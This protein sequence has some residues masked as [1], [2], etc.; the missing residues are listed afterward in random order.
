MNAYSCPHTCAKTRLITTTTPNRAARTGCPAT[1]RA[2]AASAKIASLR[3]RSAGMGKPRAR[4]RRGEPAPHQSHQ[5]R[6]ANAQCAGHDRPAA[7]LEPPVGQRG[8][9]AQL[10]EEAQPQVHGFECLHHADLSALCRGYVFAATGGSAPG[11]ALRPPVRDQP[12]GALVAGHFG[13]AGLVVGQEG[14]FGFA[15]GAVEDALA[16]FAGQAH[17]EAHIVDAVQPVAQQLLGAE[18]V[19]QIGQP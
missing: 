7:H 10:Q 16:D 17:Q 1:A 3:I 18:Q 9:G 8:Q 15:E 2:A 6:R 12:A 5:Q 14:G 19:M 13:V 11:G 4:R